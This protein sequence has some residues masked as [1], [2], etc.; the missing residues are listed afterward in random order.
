M[1]RT[2]D[3][4]GLNLTLMGTK[5]KVQLE[6]TLGCSPLNLLFGMV[7]GATTEEELDFAKMQGGATTEEELDFAKMQI[8]TL[9]VMVTILHASAQKLNANVSVDKM[10]DLIDLWLEQ[11]EENS[12]ISLFS[13]VME[14]LQTGKYLPTEVE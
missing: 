2:V 13:V 4:M 3:F 1:I 10:F 5:E 7:G 11:D 12:V 6:K 14:V 9:P 8:P